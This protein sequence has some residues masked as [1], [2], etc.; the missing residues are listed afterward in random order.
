MTCRLNKSERDV[1]VR[2]DRCQAVTC[3]RG[4][5]LEA[6]DQ[7]IFELTDVPNGFEHDLDRRGAGLLLERR[8]D[9]LEFL[10]FEFRRARFG[11]LRWFHA[12]R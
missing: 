8:K 12:C 3:V 4:V 10:Q 9:G 11:L 6:I 5:R 2:A 7:L 1:C